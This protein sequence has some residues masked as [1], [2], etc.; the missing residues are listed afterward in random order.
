MNPLT[1][2]ASRLAQQ[3][4]NQNL[5]DVRQATS[6]A[7]EGFS[8][9]RQTPVPKVLRPARFGDGFE[10]NAGQVAT[11]LVW[12]QTATKPTAA[13]SERFRD[14]F[15]I[16]QRA[17]VNLSGE[18]PSRAASSALAMSAASPKAGNGFCASLDDL[19]QLA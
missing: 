13:N 12:G 3:L 6:V 11:A 9:V 4:F 8:A 2:L 7:P 5:D 15:Q 19:P 16:A 18:Y 14:S 10:K 17:P 1:S